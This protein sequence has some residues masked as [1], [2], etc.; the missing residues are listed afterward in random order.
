MWQFSCHPTVLSECVQNEPVEKIPSL[1][2]PDTVWWCG[3]GR[4]EIDAYIPILSTI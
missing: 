3:V 2:G 4:S 1:K